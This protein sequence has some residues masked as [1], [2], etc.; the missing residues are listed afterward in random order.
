MRL[1]SGTEKTSKK[2]QGDRGREI[3]GETRIEE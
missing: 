2:R 3:G 1:S